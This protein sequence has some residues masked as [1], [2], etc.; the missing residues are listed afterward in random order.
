[1]FVRHN[2]YVCDKKYLVVWYLQDKIDVSDKTDV[3]V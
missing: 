2:W 1:M 3:G